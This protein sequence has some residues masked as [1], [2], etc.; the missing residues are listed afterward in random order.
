MRVIDAYAA[1]RASPTARRVSFCGE[2]GLPAFPLLKWQR[3][4]EM[5]TWWWMRDIPD[6]ARVRRSRLPPSTSVLVRRGR[7]SSPVVLLACMHA[8]ER[9]SSGCCSALDL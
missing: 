1:M 2:L 4:L 9:Y 5:G 6:S 3:G 8:L 7:G